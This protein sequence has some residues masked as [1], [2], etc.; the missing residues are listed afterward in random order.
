MPLVCLASVIQAT[1]P[2]EALNATSSPSWVVTPS[3]VA[4]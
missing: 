4:T 3:R 1:V 2:D